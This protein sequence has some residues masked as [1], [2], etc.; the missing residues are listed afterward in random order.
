MFELYRTD[1]F[2]A[3]FEGLRDGKGR[4]IINRRLDALAVGY[5]G[6]S[7]QVA[8]D[9]LK[10]RIHFGPGYRVYLTRRG[11]R[12]V[13]LLCGGDKRTQKRDIEKAIALAENTEIEQ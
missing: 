8:K 2:M 10:M 11:Q 1:A 12:I 7:K 6:D 9:I 4:A 5:F 3:W 13:I